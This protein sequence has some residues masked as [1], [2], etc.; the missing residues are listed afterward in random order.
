M[1]LQYT[2][3]AFLL[4]FFTNCSK[5]DNYAAPDAEITGQLVNADTQSPFQTEQPN[6]VKIRILDTKYGA[7]VSPIDIWAKAD[8]S[9]ETTQLFKGNYKVIPI[10]GAFF[11][12]D[13]ALVTTDRT[14]D[15]S[16]TVT[17]FLNINMDAA[18][19]GSS[20]IVNYSL[21]RSRVG[22]KIIEAKSLLSAYPSV[23]NSINEMSVQHD[24]SG[25]D[26][27]AVLVNNY[28]DTLKNITT[29]NSCYIRVAAKTA[30]ANGKYNYSKVVKIDF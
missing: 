27:E 7:N 29:G 24:L 8:G 1:K 2:I 11:S 12:A 19:S 14:A 16:F 21:S 13:T 6:G 9:F 17:P 3:I 26:D 4:F 30:N 28:S 18:K 5:Q 25:E 22:D 10:E 15:I 23:S 20:I